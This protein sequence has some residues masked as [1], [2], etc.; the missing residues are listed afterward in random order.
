MKWWCSATLRRNSAQFREDGAFSVGL[1]VLLAA[2]GLAGKDAQCGKS[3]KFPAQVGA[4]LA[5]NGGQGADEVPLVRMREQPS[6]DF[7]AQG[8]T[9]DSV[10]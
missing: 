7:G 3:G 9:Q 5:E 10:E 6:Q 2:L 4:V 1:V 8:R